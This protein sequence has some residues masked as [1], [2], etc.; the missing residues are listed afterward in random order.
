MISYQLFFLNHRFSKKFPVI[1]VENLESEIWHRCFA[2]NF[3]WQMNPRWRRY[4]LGRLSKIISAQQKKR[5]G[6]ILL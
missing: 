4:D 5:K 3:N 1:V 2:E 6:T